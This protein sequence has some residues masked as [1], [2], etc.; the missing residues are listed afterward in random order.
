[1]YHPPMA[2]KDAMPTTVRAEARLSYQDF[3]RFPDDGMRHEIIDGVHYVTP[4]PNHRHQQLSGRLYYAIEDHLRRHSAVGEVY[5]A[6]FDVVLTNWDVV[7]PDLLLVLADQR[8]ILTDQNVQGAPALVIEIL[9]PG[10]R[11][12]D[13]TIKRQLFERSGVREYWLVD[14]RNRSVIVFRR[15]AIGEFARVAALHADESE[16][17]TTP[18]LPDFSLEL[19]ELFA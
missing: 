11:R 14:P 19:S 16:T 5:Y 1:M 15:T 4:S 12:R 8:R 6:P 13:Q 3:L 10:T 2:G 17:L 18:L 7:E 9:S